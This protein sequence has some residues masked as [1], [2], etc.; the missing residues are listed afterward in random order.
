MP[1]AHTVSRDASAIPAQSF[2]KPAPK[3]LVGFDRPGKR[4]ANPTTSLTT[5]TLKAVRD[6]L[7]VNGA[8]IRVVTT[9]RIGSCGRKFILFRKGPT[10]LFPI[11]DDTRN[12]QCFANLTD[13]NFH[14]AL[15]EKIEPLPD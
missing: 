6:G 1:L 3:L 2:G 15:F 5:Q 14:V 13:N 4:L 8:T 11:S 12:I 9:D 10:T 7:H